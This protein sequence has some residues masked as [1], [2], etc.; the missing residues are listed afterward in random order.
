[1]LVFESRDRVGQE[2]YSFVLQLGF[3]GKL[4]RLA[5]ML[6]LYATLYVNIGSHINEIL[7]RC[8]AA[9]GSGSG[10]MTI[11][12]DLSTEDLDYFKK[13]IKLIRKECEA[14]GFSAT[15]ESLEYFDVRFEGSLPSY[16][17]VKEFFIHL[18]YTFTGELNQHLFV[19]IPLEK[20]GYF[21]RDDLFDAEVN[22]KFPKVAS[23]TKSAGDCYATGNPTASVFHLMCILEVGLD[24]LSAALGIPYSEK[25]WNEIFRSIEE[26]IAK[27]NEH[28]GNPDWKNDKSFYSQAVL[29]FKFFR[30]AWRNH[31]IH[32]RAKYSDREAE[33]IFQ[34]VKKFMEHLSTRLQQRG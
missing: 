5:D 25:N 23:D 17:E 3:A 33:S 14:H 2:Y 12:S 16:G 13:T 18:G 22:A 27:I 6:K 9:T 26:A 32:A 21:N 8:L 24:S 11:P 15:E 28:G 29:E 30:D 31:A 7:N 19:Q 10:V 20:K 4:V 34:H 1:M